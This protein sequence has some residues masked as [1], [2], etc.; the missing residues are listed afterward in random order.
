MAVSQQTS[1]N[2]Y[3]GNGFTTVYPYTFKILSATDIQVYI[4]DVLQSAGYTVSNV[5]NNSGGNITFSSAPGSAAAVTFK[6]NL[7]ID[8]TVDY[9]TAG[10]LDADSLDA[11][12]DRTVMLIQDVKRDLTTDGSIDWSNVNNKPS[13]LTGYGITDAAPSSH[14][15]GLTVTG[16]VTGSGTGSVNLTLATVNGSV[17]SYGDATTVPVITVNSKGLITSVSTA[18]ISGGG[19]LPSQTGNNGKFLTTDGT[20][21]S[22]ATV[23]GWR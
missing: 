3:Y 22:W 9:L 17:G 14:S 20:N 21:A 6:R 7:T 10:N 18:T 23:T 2:N 4:N 12:I 8:R 1:I 19:S 13:T 5:G 11:D 16:D 15:H